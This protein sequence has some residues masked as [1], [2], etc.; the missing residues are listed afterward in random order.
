MRRIEHQQ[1][2][3]INDYSVMPHLWHMPQLSS[4]NCIR[5]SPQ[6]LR[7]SDMAKAAGIHVNTVRMYEQWGLIPPVERSPSGYR[8]FKEIC[9]RPGRR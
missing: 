8:R 6:Y 2:E 5:M 9:R 3:P 7:T 4:Y 1:I